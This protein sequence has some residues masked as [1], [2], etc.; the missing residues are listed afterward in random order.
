MSRPGYLVAASVL[1]S[2]LL[3][4]QSQAQDCTS[5]LLIVLDR[6]C[7]MTSNSIMGKTRWD[8]AVAAINKLAANNSGKIRFGLA[9]FPNKTTTTPKCV[10]TNPLLAPAQGNEQAVV[11]FLFVFLFF[12]F[13]FC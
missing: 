9:M 12:F 11:P 3:P 8:I 10:Q 13:F 1:C 6:S 4:A 5:N 2:L 7:S